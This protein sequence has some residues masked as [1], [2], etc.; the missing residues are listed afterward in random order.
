MKVKTEGE[1]FE[2]PLL[3]AGG[4]EPTPSRQKLTHGQV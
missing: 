3:A 2:H 1:R 4:I